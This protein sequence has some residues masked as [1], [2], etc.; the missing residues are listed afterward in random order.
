MTG[1][2]AAAVTIPVDRWSGWSPD[3]GVLVGLAGVVVVYLWSVRQLWSSAGRRVGISRGRVLL[4]LTGMAVL[5]VALASP[6]DAVADDLFSAHMAQH[7]LLTVVAAPLLVAGRLP[8]VLRPL[9]PVALR[10]GLAR[11]IRRGSW[12]AAPV[13]LAAVALLHLLV[14]IAWHVPVLYDLAVTTPWAHA[15]EHLTMLGAA[16]A[17]W[18]SMGAGR[19]RSVPAAGLAAFVVSLSFIG[20]AA[21]LTVAPGPWYGAHLATTAAWGLTPL[22]DQ[23]LAAA[24]MWLPGGLVYLGATAGSVVRWLD[25]D[26]RT[27]T[28]LRGPTVP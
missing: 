7:L 10:R 16:A 2:L 17:F 12:R 11:G 23:Q 15:A 5:V 25:E 24:L 6:L 14:V 20:L 9:T 26:E 13:V 18:A 19:R 4:F 8:L 27:N 28:L 1:W 22:E 3:P 21:A